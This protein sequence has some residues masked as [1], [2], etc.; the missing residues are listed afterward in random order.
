MR[1]FRFPLEGPLGNKHTRHLSYKSPRDV[2]TLGAPA[3]SSLQ[4]WVGWVFVQPLWRLPL[5]GVD[6]PQLQSD[7]QPSPQS[8]FLGHI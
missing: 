2:A 7:L 4:S 3:A 5:T 8:S 1:G 6:I